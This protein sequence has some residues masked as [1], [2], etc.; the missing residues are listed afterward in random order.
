[1]GTVASPDI[2]E[3]S[4]LAASRMT[5]GLLWAHNDSGDSARVFALT[6]QGALRGVYSLPT[7]RTNDWEDIAIGPKPGAAGDFLYL[8]DM[9]DNMGRR[10][11]GIV[12]HRVPEPPVSL[13]GQASAS[14]AT[15]KGLES[16]RLRYPDGPRDAET[17]LVDPKTGELVIVTKVMFGAPRIY[18]AGPKL[19][20]ESMLSGGEPLD[21]DKAGIDDGLFAT[22]GDVSPDGRFVIVRGYGNAYLWQRD[23]ARPLHEAF[24]GRACRVPVAS[25]PQGEA[26]AFAADGSGYFTLSEKK[27]QPIYFF[28]RNRAER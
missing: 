24:S 26:V 23:P 12:I 20:T 22:S 27:E 2:D 11:E 6:A 7:V 19:A 1:M 15:L 4:G 21:F 18:Y 25:E 9:G 8:G 28:S 17:L 16:F 13:Q 3:A 10:S 5:P 14:E